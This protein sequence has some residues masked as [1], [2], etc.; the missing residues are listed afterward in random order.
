MR[1]AG[2]FLP[3]ALSEVREA[4]DFLRFYAS[5]ARRTLTTSHQAF[6][7]VVCIS[8]WTFPLAIF[9]GQIIA[10]LV[11]GNIVLAKPAEES[12]LIAAQAVK[13]L[14]EAGCPEYALQLVP[15]DGNIGAALVGCDQIAAVLFTGSTQ[16]VRSIQKELASRFAPSG[17]FVPLIA[18]TGGRNAMIVDSSA[19]AE[20]LVDDVI[21]SAFDSGGQRCSALRL[22]CL[23]DDVADNILTMLK[24][25]M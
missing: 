4:I 13:L 14:Y 16:V 5:Q 15:D 12:P 3:N 21:A 17:K 22:L 8:P 20:Q 19:L 23:Q 1:Q 7:V 24:G 18:E 11:T 25:A 2:K 6:G 9:M 10:A